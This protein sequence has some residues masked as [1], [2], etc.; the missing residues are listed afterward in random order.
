MHKTR[1]AP[2]EDINDVV[3]YRKTFVTVRT[4]VMAHLTHDEIM[5]EIRRNTPLAQINNMPENG[6]IVEIRSTERRLTRTKV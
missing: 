1:I 5:R 6:V 4:E 3:I 2:P